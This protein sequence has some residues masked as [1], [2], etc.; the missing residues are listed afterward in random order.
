MNT[1]QEICY[2][3]FL[4]AMKNN[5]ENKMKKIAQSDFDVNAVNHNGKTL[6]EKAVFEGSEEAVKVLM[7][8]GANPNVQY[9]KNCSLL[10]YATTYKSDK[11]CKMLTSSI[12]D[13]NEVN[14]KGTT[15]TIRAAEKGRLAL[16]KHYVM[17]GAD[18][19]IGYEKEQDA[20]I[21]A[22]QIYQTECAKFLRP[23]QDAQL[24]AKEIPFRKNSKWYDYDD[25][26]EQR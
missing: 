9:S 26:M 7:A 16:L 6:L 5:D 3:H 25:G 18:L 12:E 10:L 22:R 20:V 19:T 1:Q 14:D 17:K 8:N 23:I 15:V 24:K 11:I 2:N 4:N 13:I 21:L